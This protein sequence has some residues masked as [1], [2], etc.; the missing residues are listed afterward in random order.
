MDDKLL[1]LQMAFSIVADAEDY[2]RMSIDSRM[3]EVRRVFE[4]LENLMNGKTEAK[5]LQ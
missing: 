4:R 1:L 2:T 5:P 3:D